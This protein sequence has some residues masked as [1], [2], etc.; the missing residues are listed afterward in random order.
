MIDLGFSW[1][2]TG[3]IVKWRWFENASRLL[4]GF[5]G[6]SVLKHQ[7][8]FGPWNHLRSLFVWDKTK[9]CAECCAVN[10]TWFEISVSA[11][12]CRKRVKMFCWYVPTVPTT[13]A[14]VPTW[15]QSVIISGR[16]EWPHVWTDHI[17]SL[18]FFFL[19]PGR[20][21]STLSWSRWPEGN[22]GSW[23]AAP[24]TTWRQWRRASVSWLACWRTR[25]Q[26][27]RGYDAA[28]ANAETLA[29]NEEEKSPA[30]CWCPCSH[31]HA[32][33]TCTHKKT[34]Q[35]SGLSLP[36]VYCMFYPSLRSHLFVLGECAHAAVSHYSLTEES[37]H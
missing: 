34:Q 20:S 28:A 24:P 35:M 13:A 10:N 11:S 25:T 6:C 33:Q 21:R 30:S 14:V 37:C 31:T 29:D 16:P 5:Q 18:S 4:A 9:K 32:Q 12:H 8:I 22:A 36:D 17:L 15:S 7:V 1:F 23:R 2:L 3:W 26:S 19:C 27:P